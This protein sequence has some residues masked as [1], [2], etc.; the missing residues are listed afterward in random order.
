MVFQFSSIKNTDNFH[1]IK[2]IFNDLQ[3]SYEDTK[4]TN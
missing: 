4:V 2:K 1:K 3:I